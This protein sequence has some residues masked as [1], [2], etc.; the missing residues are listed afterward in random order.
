MI[1]VIGLGSPFGDDDAGWRVVDALRGQVSRGTELVALDRPGALLVSRLV[2]AGHLVLVDALQT[3]GRV[4]GIRRLDPLDLASPGF[5]CGSH[6]LRLV[7]QLALAEVLGCRPRGIEL[8]TIAIGAIGDRDPAVELA[9]R[10]LAATLARRLRIVDRAAAPAALSR[11]GS[12][13]S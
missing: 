12:R 10:Q 13:S 6:Q 3:A 5:D 2:D 4:G 9:V 8:W 7:D 11:A 1:R